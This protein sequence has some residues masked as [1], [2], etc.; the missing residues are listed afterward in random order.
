M[1]LDERSIDISRY[2]D[3]ETLLS[4]YKHF[5]SETNLFQLVTLTIWRAKL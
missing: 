2:N 5:L 1:G 4:G 3:N